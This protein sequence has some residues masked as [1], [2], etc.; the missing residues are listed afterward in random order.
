MVKVEILAVDGCPHREAALKAVQNAVRATGVR[1]QIED[2][3]VND[4][5]E[6]IAHAMSGSPTVRVNGHDVEP[7]ALPRGSFSCRL[8]PGGRSA[9]R[10]EVL[11]SMLRLASKAVPR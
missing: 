9:P 10:A 4:E 2:V 6:A 11:E 5:T 8:Y 3:L 1:A 7:G